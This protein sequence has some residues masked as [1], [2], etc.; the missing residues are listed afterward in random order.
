MIFP[1]IKCIF[2]SGTI[3]VALPGQS[4]SLPQDICT[5]ILDY[6]KPPNCIILAITE[7]GDIANSDALR[8]AKIV[9]PKGIRTLGVI[10][11]LDLMDDGTDAKYS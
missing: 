8:L 2:I 5:M 1:I 6:I 9:D 11:K 7:A 10:T 4:E 3:S